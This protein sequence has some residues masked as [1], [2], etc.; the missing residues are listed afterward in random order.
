MQHYNATECVQFVVH[1]MASVLTSQSESIA[2]LEA[3][4]V[5]L[6]DARDM[7]MKDVAALEGKLSSAMADEIGRLKFWLLVVVVGLIIVR[8]FGYL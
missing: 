1:P 2:R 4:V 7:A 6:C 5:E 8:R 3:L